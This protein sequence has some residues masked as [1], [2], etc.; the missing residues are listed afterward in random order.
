MNGVVQACIFCGSIADP[1][2][3]GI[4]IAAKEQCPAVGSDQQEMHA[5]SSGCPSHY[6]WLIIGSLMLY[7]AAFSPGMGPVPWAVNAEIYPAQVK[8]ACV[9]WLPLLL[10]SHS[11]LQQYLG[12]LCL[13]SSTSSNLCIISSFT[14]AIIH[15]F[16]HL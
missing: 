12:S 10:S 9:F 7:L 11:S 8:A 16:T 2:A 5:Y 4:C 6:N 14:H 3:P 1:M 15:A 13:L